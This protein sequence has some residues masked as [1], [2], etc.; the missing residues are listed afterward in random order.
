M[1][2][3]TRLKA[4]LSTCGSAHGSV[5]YVFWSVGDRPADYLASWFGGRR[6]RVTGEWLD[7]LSAGD[8]ILVV[9]I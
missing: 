3:L 5:G 2:S 7:S 8:Y 6:N 1:R 4:T 9:M